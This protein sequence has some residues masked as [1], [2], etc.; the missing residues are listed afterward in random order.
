[1][2]AADRIGEPP[3]GLSFPDHASR[4]NACSDLLTHQYNGMFNNLEYTDI[5]SSRSEETRGKLRGLNRNASVSRLSSSVQAATNTLTSPSPKA[6]FF[7]YREAISA[8]RRVP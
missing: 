8:R 5:A 1:M 6:K 3:T 4:S 7:A 2:G